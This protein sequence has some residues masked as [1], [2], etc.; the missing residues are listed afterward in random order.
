MTVPRAAINAYKTSV[1]NSILDGQ[2]IGGCVQIA[3]SDLE[4]G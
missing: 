2:S 3:V 4:L 1:K